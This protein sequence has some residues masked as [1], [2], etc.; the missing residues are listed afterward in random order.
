VLFIRTAAVSALGAVFIVSL[1]NDITYNLVIQQFKGV[2]I[3]AFTPIVLVGI[4]LLFYI[5]NLPFSQKIQKAKRLLTSSISVL[6]IVSA[7]LLLG[8]SY[9]YLTRTGND[10]Q[11][12]P[13]EL[14]FRSFLEDTLKARPRTKEFLI[15]NPLLIL[16]IYLVLKHRLNAL[17]L[18]FIG[19]IGQASFLGSFTHLHTPLKISIIRGV[20]G[21]F[22][23]ALIAIV[24]IVIW[25]I[26]ARGWKKWAQPQ[27]V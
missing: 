9:Y 26:C 1:L 27:H 14:L 20:Y 13:F 11:A 6:W 4:Y 2:N 16:G 3:L 17:Y 23:G 18:V 7:V 8:I 12:S 22:F 21:M 25:E 19:V 10:G 5:D 24:L 15:G